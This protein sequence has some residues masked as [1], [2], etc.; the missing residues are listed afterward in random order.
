MVITRPA[1]P[2][3]LAAL[4][5]PYRIDRPA[6]PLTLLGH[7]PFPAQVTSGDRFTL[8]LFWQADRSPLSDYRVRIRLFDP[9]G[10]VALERLWPLSPY[11][12]S[13]WR[14]GDRFESRY[15][16]HVLPDLP[17][18][19]YRLALNV[20]DGAGDAVWAAD[21]ELGTVEVMARPRTFALPH[22][23]RPLDL[24]F[25]DAVRLRGYDLDRSEALP[26][27]SLHLT[28]YWQ[29]ERF[30]ERE[31][32]LFVHLLGPDGLPHGQVDRVPG[33]G[34]AP[35][36]SWAAGQ[37]IVEEVLL[38]VAADAPPGRY[39]IAVGFYDPL[40]GARLPVTDGAGR[41]LPDD[42]AGLPVDSAVGSSP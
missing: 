16:V 41:R 3:D 13:R 17:P 35:S 42:R 21:L 31:Y 38:P 18:A 8:P 32:T 28:L 36:T 12:T 20:V 2:L 37:V 25:G 39:T 30:T 6:G 5:I 19:P 4:A 14:S 11:P 24:S 7:V 26:G 34:L 40:Y 15:T 9:G 33:D 10:G 23:P 1:A 29:A 27:E 22:I